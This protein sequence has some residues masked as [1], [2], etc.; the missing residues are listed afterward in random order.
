MKE[1]LVF[2]LYGPMASWG[3]VAVGEYRPTM[4]Y[5]SKS[6]VLGLL[7]AA[8]GIRRHEDDKHT[9]LHIGYGFAVCVLGAGELLRDYHTT[10]VPAGNRFYATRRDELC[11][12]SL[13]LST[14]LSQRDYRM[15]SLCLVALWQKESP[16]FCLQHLQEKLLQPHFSLYLGRKSCPPALPLNPDIIKEKTLKLAFSKYPSD[17]GVFNS[18]RLRDSL[19]RYFWEQDGIDESCLGLKA[20]MTYPRRDQILSRNR[21]QFASRDE[22]FCM[23]TSKEGQ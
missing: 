23:E 22:Y 9:A 14:I 6:A 5:P 16:P 2:Q 3:D 17:K 8:L 7:A 13:K 20:V 11:Y 19:V 10:Q 1:F 21:W 4:N 18:P 15:D 12:D